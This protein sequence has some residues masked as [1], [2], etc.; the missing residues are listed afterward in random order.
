MDAT[1]LNVAAPVK[2]SGTPAAV[3]GTPATV[4]TKPSAIAVA[5]HTLGPAA[6][7]TPHVGQ[8]P[9]PIVNAHTPGPSGFANG[10]QIKGSDK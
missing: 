9:P 2:A 8:V 3:Q 4:E 5:G 6:Y 7:A 1:P 10:T